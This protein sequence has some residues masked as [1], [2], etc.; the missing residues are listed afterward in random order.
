M[1]DLISY[2]K[3]SLYG[4]CVEKGHTSLK[5]AREQPR[6][7]SL[8]LPWALEPVSLCHLVPKSKAP[9][10]SIDS[11][12]FVRSFV[13]LFVCLFVCLFVVLFYFEVR[14]AWGHVVLDPLV[15]DPEMFCMV[16]CYLGATT[17]SHDVANCPNSLSDGFG[18]LLH[19]M[20]EPACQHRLI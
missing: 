19:A 14:V 20:V 7:W 16:Q 6:N 3:L 8:I 2:A 18:M 11:C 10:G 15:S 13:G 9:A 12:L 4:S 1:I 5:S 17:W